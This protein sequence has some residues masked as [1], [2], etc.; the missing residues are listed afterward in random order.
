VYTH[1]FEDEDEEEGEDERF[2][3]DKGPRDSEQ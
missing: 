1:L 3:I 2:P